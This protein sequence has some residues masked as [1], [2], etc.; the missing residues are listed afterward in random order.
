LT[1]GFSGV[2]AAG[3]AGSGAAGFSAGFEAA[4]SA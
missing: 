4:L 1:F 2:A 3:L